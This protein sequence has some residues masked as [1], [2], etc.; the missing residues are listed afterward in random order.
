MSKRRDH[1]DQT[2]SEAAL[3]YLEKLALPDLKRECIVRGLPFEQVGA[4]S[5]L[6]L[7]SFFLHKFD[8]P[9]DRGLL[10]KYDLWVTKELQSRGVDP[11]LYSDAFKLGTIIVRDSG[12][13]EFRKK[14][15]GSRI[16]KVRE[17]KARTEDNL[18]VGTKKAY[19]FELQKQGLSKPEVITKVLEKF[20]DAKEKS[21]GIWYNKARRVQKA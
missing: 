7:Q 5:V 14:R 3:T 20:P 21:I 2:V 11:L 15:S 8:T 9:E 6:Q 10:D 13:G 1:R 18:Y 16:P 19:T 4:M 17:K 12:T